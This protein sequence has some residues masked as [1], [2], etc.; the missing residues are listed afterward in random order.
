[1]TNVKQLDEYF[2]KA[3]ARGK[4]TSATKDEGAQQKG[5]NLFQPEPWPEPVSGAEVLTDVA[6]SLRKH[7]AMRRVDTYTAA[8]WCVHCHCF[9]QFQHSPLLA[10]SAP[11]PECGKSV[12]LSLIGALV[13][14]PQSTDN[15]SPA[16]FFRLAESHKPTFLIDEV[17]SWFKKDNDLPSA[18]NASFEKNGGGVLR[19]VGDKHEVQSFNTYTPVALCGIN[20]ARRIMPATVT[21]SI[22]IELQ[23]AL[24]GEVS[25]SFDQRRHRQNLLT[26]NRKIARWVADQDFK[27]C[28]PTMPPGVVNRKADKWRPLL[29]I[30]DA[31]GGRWPEW[32]RAALNSEPT[33][34]IETREIELLSDITEVLKVYSHLF[35]DVVFTKELIRALCEPEESIWKDYNSKKHL[36]DERC[37]QPRQLAN[38]LKDF[39]LRPREQRKGDDKRR[40]FKRKDLDAVIARYLPA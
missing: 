11:A 27:D 22:L 12:L 15:M 9:D 26:L 8:L 39:H 38:L 10:I 7:M 24:P 3:E 4:T 31:A 32:A 2:D 34:T 6:E 16:P 5:I 19:C 21:R 1:M 33:A 14:R 29:A 36:P 37:L 25:I 28:D 17:D 30:A 20:V 18:I 23:R 40:G 13:P 35:V